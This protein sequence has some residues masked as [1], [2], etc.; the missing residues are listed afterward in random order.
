[1]LLNFLFVAFIGIHI[2][3]IGLLFRALW[4]FSISPNTILIFA[5]IMTLLASGY[6]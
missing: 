6:F 5:L 3:L 4:N 1:M 2:P